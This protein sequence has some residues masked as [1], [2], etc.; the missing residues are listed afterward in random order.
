MKLKMTTTALIAASMAFTPVSRAQAD[1][2]DVAA[3]VLL[4]VLGSA[5]VN[6][7]K[8]KKKKKYYKSTSV[9]SATRAENRQVQTSLNYFGFPAGGADGVLGR[10]SRTAISSYQVYMGYPATG[11]LTDF[12]RGFLINSYNRAMAGGAATTQMVAANPQGTRGLLLT[13][14]DEMAGL[15]TPGVAPQA[16]TTVVVTP[17][18]TVPQSTTTTVVAATAPAADAAPALPSFLGQETEVSLASHCNKVSLLTSSNGG[19]TT[20]ASM[21]DPEFTLGEQFCLARTYAIATG[22]D[23]TAKV[24]GYTPAQIESQCEAFGPAMKEYVSALSIKPSEDVLRDVSGFVL[25]TGMSPAQLSGTAKIC[26]SVGYRTDK[27][28]VAIGSALMLVALGERVYGELPGHH[29]SL[30]FGASQRRD[31][32]QAWYA[33]A[34]DALNTGATPAFAPGQPERSALLQQAS[35]GLTAPAGQPGAA[36]PTGLIPAFSVGD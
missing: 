26:L 33:T 8:K 6:D 30:G 14:R 36:A 10:K 7:A 24:Q 9:P 28:D 35:Y 12:E 25:K 32:A 20:L 34:V 21:S 4:G 29:L 19:F 11:Y 22:E 27:M 2:G 23:L 5:V 16:T 3:G 31:L 17:Q 1:G 18:A 13:Y 15:T